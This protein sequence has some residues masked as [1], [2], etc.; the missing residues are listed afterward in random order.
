VRLASS[1]V[2]EIQNCKMTWL[3]ETPKAF[4]TIFLWKQLKKSRIMTSDTVKTQR[5]LQWAIR[6]LEPN[7]AMIGQGSVSETA[8]A[9]VNNEGLINRSLLKVQSSLIGNYRESPR[10]GLR[11]QIKKFYYFFI[12]IRILLDFSIIYSI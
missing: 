11:F 3:R 5:I 4:A 1:L 6:R 7:S 9:S 8:K 10:E 12:Y 2:C